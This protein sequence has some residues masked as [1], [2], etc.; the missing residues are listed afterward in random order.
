[1]GVFLCVC[2]LPV[3]GVWCLCRRGCW[4]WNFVPMNIFVGFGNP[5]PVLWKSNQY[6]LNIE[7]SLQPQPLVY[8]SCHAFCPLKHASNP[9]RK[10]L[11]SPDSSHAVITTVA[12]SCLAGQV[13]PAGFTTGWDHWW[14]CSPSSLHFES[15]PAGKRFPSLLQGD[16]SM[17]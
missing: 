3:C 8:G 10:H 7:P 2:L 4:N 1:M 11:I 14:L 16:F 6:S 13:I 17:H 15:Y 9:I 12:T 5:T